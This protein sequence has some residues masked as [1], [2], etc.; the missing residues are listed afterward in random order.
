MTSQGT[1]IVVNDQPANLAVV[2]NH[3]QSA[4]F[5]VLVHTKGE[6][7]LESIRE[8]QPDLVLLEIRIPGMD[9]FE[10]CSRLKADPG[11]QDIP[12]I[13]I[14]ALFRTTSIN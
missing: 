2:F 4:D 3:L 7:A 13:F 6:S 11:T 14:T 8:V 1:I 12:V 5:K 10:V 9:G